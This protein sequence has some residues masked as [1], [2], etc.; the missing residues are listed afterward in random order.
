MWE[1]ERERESVCVSRKVVK[2][3]NSFSAKVC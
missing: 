2:M 1:R 3:A